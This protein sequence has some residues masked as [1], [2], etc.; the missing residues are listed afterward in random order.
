VIKQRGSVL[1]DVNAVIDKISSTT[2]YN[3]KL[4]SAAV[5]AN[6]T[7]NKKVEDRQLSNLISTKESSNTLLQ[8][9]IYGL[10]LE[11]KPVAYSD[12]QK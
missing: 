7:V 8:L 2:Q 6:D 3:I 4:L 12:I 9:I 5:I 11:E 1:E 10:D